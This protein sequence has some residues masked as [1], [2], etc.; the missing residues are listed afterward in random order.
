MK[1]A[2]KTGTSDTNEK[3]I[4]AA[5]NDVGIITLASGDHLALSIFISDTTESIGDS[6]KLI[7]ALSKAIVD[8]YS[9]ISH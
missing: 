3:G 8:N 1:V 4:T 6:E 9:Q 2:H 7:A 5:V